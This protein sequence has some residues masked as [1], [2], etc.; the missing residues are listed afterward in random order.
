MNESKK[1]ERKKEKNGKKDIFA[2]SLHL[3]SNTE[4]Q[5]RN[6]S[7]QLSPGKPQPPGIAVNSTQQSFYGPPAISL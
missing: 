2:F 1:E 5:G 6:K 7:S 3:S 4:F